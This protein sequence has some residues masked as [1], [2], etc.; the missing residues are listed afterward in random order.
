MNKDTALRLALEALESKYIVG[1]G[2]WQVQKDQAIT[3]LRL[4]IDV[5]NMASKTTYKEALETKDEPKCVAIVEVFGKDWRI[6]YISLPVGKH[7]LYA[8]QYTYTTTPQPET[9]YEPVAYINVEERKLE[10][11][12]KFI[13]WETPTVVNLPKIPLYT[14]PQQRKPLT[15]EQ[16]IECDK[17]AGLNHKRHHWSI[18][19]QQMTPAD[20]FWWHFA[21]AIEAAHGIKE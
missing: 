8:Q 6:D 2:A 5:E 4:A 9:K 19:S 12:N 20:D 1:S 17:I 13:T 7:N 21:R 15:D 3:A 10:W 16:I 11:A 14:T 18:K